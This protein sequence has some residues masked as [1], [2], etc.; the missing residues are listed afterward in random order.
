MLTIWYSFSIPSIKISLQ[1]KRAHFYIKKTHPLWGHGFL[2]HF[3]SRHGLID[4][5]HPPLGIMLCI[6][7]CI[8]C[9]PLHFSDGLCDAA[10][11]S[12]R[13][14]YN[15]LCWG[16]QSVQQMFNRLL[17][18]AESFIVLNTWV[19][20]L[21]YQQHP[22]EERNRLKQI[23]LW[24]LQTETKGYSRRKWLQYRKWFL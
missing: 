4:S 6:H 9:I 20:L 2:S 5:I 8:C 3:N 11:F 19:N 21:H 15:T 7:D 23:V 18:G 13:W 1:G 14:K 17:E 16:V 10:S 24:A 12:V 22:N